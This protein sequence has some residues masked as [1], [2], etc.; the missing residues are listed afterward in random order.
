MSIAQEEIFGPVLCIIPYDSEDEAVAI[1]NDSP[2]GLSGAVTS[3]SIE[4]ASEVALRVRTGE[5]SVNGGSYNPIAPFGGY[6]SFF[7]QSVLIC[8]FLAIVRN[9][10]IIKRDCRYVR[11]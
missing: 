5:M 10:P 11:L 2:Y 4:R 3:R 9:F 7:F 1:A 8:Y 6:A